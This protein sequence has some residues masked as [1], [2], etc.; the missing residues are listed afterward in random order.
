VDAGQLLCEALAKGRITPISLGPTC[1]TAILLERLGLRRRAFPFDWLFSSL[2]M[3]EHCLDD[4]F[5]TFLDPA[6]HQPLGPRTT[7]HV[8]YRDTFGVEEV[9]EHHAMPTSRGHFIRAIERF[10]TAP[11]PVFLHISKRPPDKSALKRLRARLRGPL[12]AYAVIPAPEGFAPE[13]RFLLKLAFTVYRSTKKLRGAGF[14]DPD[15]EP[16]FAARVVADLTA[17]LAERALHAT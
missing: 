13:E 15:D 12:L 2:A 7:D 3:V 8:F 10:K 5:Q 14:T 1:Y 9:F 4:D 11:N 17:V 6:Q 16:A